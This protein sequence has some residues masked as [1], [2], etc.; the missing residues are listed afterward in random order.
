MSNLEASPAAPPA[1]PTHPE[2]Q[3]PMQQQPSADQLLEMIRQMKL[4]LKLEK[5]EKFLGAVRSTTEMF[6]WVTKTHWYLTLS[7]TKPEL[8]VIYA[9]QFLTGTVQM[10]YNS[11]AGPKYQT[12]AD[13]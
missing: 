11:V 7:E 9:S 4:Q 2:M 13:N 6:N 10:W 5:P 1:T 3:P 12:P 8:C